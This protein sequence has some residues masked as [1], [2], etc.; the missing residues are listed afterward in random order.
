MGGKTE[1]V[2]CR[3]RGWLLCGSSVTRHGR[4]RR[5]QYCSGNVRAVGNA[6]NMGE[7]KHS[8]GCRGQPRMA[9]ERQ[10]CRLE[11]GSMRT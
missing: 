7:N 2:G 4:R 5:K 9:N 3:R 1:R 8:V 6:R 10:C 11:K